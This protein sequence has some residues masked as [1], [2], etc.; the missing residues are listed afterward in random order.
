MVAVASVVIFPES[1]LRQ[2]T[3]LPDEWIFGNGTPS[4]TAGVPSNLDDNCRLAEKLSRL[5]RDCLRHDTDLPLRTDDVAVCT[6]CRPSTST[7]PSLAVAVCHQFSCNSP[8]LSIDLVNHYVGTCSR[9]MADIG[10]RLR[11]DLRQLRLLLF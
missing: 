1:F 2:Q 8:V 3:N 10:E 5:N 7:R 9:R 6:C 11:D 4:L